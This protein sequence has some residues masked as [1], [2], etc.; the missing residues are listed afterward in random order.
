MKNE[1]INELD[2]HQAIFLL[3]K[4]HNCIIYGLLDMQS[5]EEDLTHHDIGVRSLSKIS[6]QEWKDA[7]EYAID[8]DSQALCEEYQCLEDL[9]ADYLRENHIAN[10]NNT[11]GGFSSGK[12]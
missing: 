2:L 1:N 9:V 6:R 12:M 7:M 4:K 10:P 5:L 3:E 11:L 8:T